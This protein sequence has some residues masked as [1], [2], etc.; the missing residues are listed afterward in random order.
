[1]ESNGHYDHD[2]Y[3]KARFEMIVVNFATKQHL[4][5]Q[6]RLRE[7]L[8]D[9]GVK[10]LGFNSYAEIG[11]PTHEQS[12]YHFKVHAI[13]KALQLDPVVLWADSSMWLVGD[14]KRIES[15]ILKD[16]YF[17]EEAGH[18]VKDWCNDAALKYFGLDRTTTFKLFSAGLIGL[19][20]TSPIARTWLHEW[21]QAA[22]NGHFKGSW[23][24]H[25]HDMTCGSIIAEQ[26]GMKYQTGASHM[27]YIGEGYTEPG[28]DVV[29]YAQGM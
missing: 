1:M 11:S 6:E 10:F 19:N 26:L 5:G 23:E 9:S 12:P 7:S 15:V 27:A 3:P 18:N 29:F 13:K 16:G 8:K 25:R 28:K 20:G 14:I 21:E 17:F 22:I 4:K 2:N 24:D